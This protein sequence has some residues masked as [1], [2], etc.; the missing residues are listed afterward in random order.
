[1]NLTYHACGDSFGD[2]LWFY[3][4]ARAWFG[5]GAK[6]CAH[7]YSAGAHLGLLVGATRPDLY[8]VVSQAGPT[9]LTTI[10]GELAYDAA[11]GQHSQTLGGRY[12][13]NLAAAAFG[14]ENLPAYSPAAQAATSLKDTR[15][16]QGFSADDPL[17]PYQ[18]AA[19]L[20]GAMQAA[21]PGAYVDNL[22]L[23]TGTIPF[24]HGGVTQAALND[25]YAAERR[26][27]APITAPTVAL[28]RR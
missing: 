17:V 6:I 9:D 5:P 3:D 27:V 21:N 19:D 4:K 20:A 28:D 7:G 11:T 2:V 24:G 23:E 18:Q 12:V 16:L 10:Q 22:Q 14:E 26:L 8:C 1:V 15:V 13:H 25:Y